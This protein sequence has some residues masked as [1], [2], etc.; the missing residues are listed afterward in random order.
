PAERWG[1]P[2][3]EPPRRGPPCLECRGRGAG[4]GHPPLLTVEPPSDSSADLSDRSD[5]G[6]I[7][8]GGPYEPEGAGGGTLPR[9]G[10][11]HRCFH[12]EGPPPPP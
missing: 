12:P 1:G 10:P 6:S 4:G 3:E 9:S 2:P 7:N 5:R 11:P 8:R